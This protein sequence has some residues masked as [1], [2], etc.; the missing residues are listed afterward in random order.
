MASL[1]AVVVMVE[2]VMVVVIDPNDGGVG[3]LA[4]LMVHFRLS[5]CG[6]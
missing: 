3:I 2:V 5:V 4:S 6:S 1:A